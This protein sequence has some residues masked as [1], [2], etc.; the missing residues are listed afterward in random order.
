M[1]KSSGEKIII[2]LII[3]AVI[4]PLA[5]I[6]DPTMKLSSSSSSSSSLQRSD[7]IIYIALVVSAIVGLALYPYYNK[8]NDNADDKSKDAKSA[9]TASSSTATKNPIKDIWKVGQKCMNM[10]KN[11]KGY[12][13]KP[14][15]SKYYYAHNDSNTT[16]GYKDGLKMED[17]RM[18]GPRL[19]SRNGLSI[20]ETTANYGGNN[21]DE[22][23]EK[24]TINVNQK[25]NDFDYDNVSNEDEE[26]H[27]VNIKN[28]TKYLWDDPG[29][30][31]G[32]GTIRIDVL[33]SSTSSQQ[34]YIDV[35][36]VT[37]EDVNATLIAGGRGLLVKIIVTDRGCYQLKINKLY[38][39]ASDVKVIIKQ[40]R[41]LIKIYKKE[42]NLTAWLQP[43]KKV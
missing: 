32:I 21:D 23:E 27:L 15:G 3:G 18:N 16:G 9:T 25:Y 14:F 40:K 29:D 7:E 42:K 12:K 8:Q 39:D 1:P 19:L 13:E 4:I 36:D 20:D 22:E 26:V 24:E 31:R 30:S 28:I 43:H 33:P 6:I 34:Q 38:G 11:S 17:Y 35:K 2:S 10:T 37:V 5:A 41:L